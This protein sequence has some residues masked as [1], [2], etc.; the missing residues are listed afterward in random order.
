MRIKIFVVFV[1]A[2]VSLNLSAKE[3]K[4]AS[5]FINSTI[6][7][8]DISEGLY[9]TL[10]GGIGINLNS[11]LSLCCTVLYKKY[12]E[13]WSYIVDDYTFYA[14][15]LD[16]KY[17]LRNKRLS[18]Y[19][20]LS[21]GIIAFKTIE[22]SYRQQREFRKEY[23]AF[24]FNI[25]GGLGINFR[26]NRVISLFFEFRHYLSLYSFDMIGSFGFSPIVIGMVINL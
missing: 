20:L 7:L 23:S 21:E 24:C 11:K 26:F 12:K 4:S 16:F 2:L 14:C 8:P 18:S 1:L 15:F 25:G 9:P 5:F 10:G 17:K 3:G 13:K 19:F 22:N 6:V